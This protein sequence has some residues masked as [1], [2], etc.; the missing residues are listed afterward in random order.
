MGDFVIMGGTSDETSIK[1][2][3]VALDRVE[4][5]TLIPVGQ[6]SGTIDAVSKKWFC[7]IP[8]ARPSPSAPAPIADGK[9][10]VTVVAT[11]SA[12]RTATIKEV[13]YID[14]TAPLV[15]IT[16]PSTKATGL[17]DPFGGEVEFSGMLWD[18][19]QCA[20]MTIRFYKRQLDGSV[21]EIAQHVAQNL[22]QNWTVTIPVAT[23]ALL[24]SAMDSAD[25]AQKYFYTLE[26]SDSAVSYNDEAGFA[27]V[28]GGN[29]CRHVF[30]YDDV[31]GLLAMGESFPSGEQLSLVNDGTLASAGSVTVANLA[32]IA[33]SSTVC[34][35]A[36]S[37]SLSID[38]NN[39][40]PTAEVAGMTWLPSATFDS[41]FAANQIAGQS[42]LNVTISP[43][44]DNASIQSGSVYVYLRARGDADRTLLPAERIAVA[45][46]VASGQKR[47]VNYE[48]AKTS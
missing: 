2:V 31:S 46:I 21:V 30:I 7:R 20:S 39:K 1:S 17:A 4:G 14:N 25:S 19:N 48:V 22:P 9:Y 38:P 23:F 36:L 35:S 16:R 6:W 27:S 29:A 12:N 40:N 41:G 47:I 44:P 34:D 32:S 13:Y 42:I 15:V 45:N 8:N 43:G 11:D 3:S 28:G 26:A 33:I 18:G 10:Q 5:S 24:E 37:G